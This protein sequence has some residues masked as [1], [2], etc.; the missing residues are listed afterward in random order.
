YYTDPLDEDS[1]ND[2]MFDGFEVIFGFNPLD[3]AD[4]S[5]DADADGL[6]NL[7][8]FQNNTN[9]LYADTDLDGLS[10]YQ[11]LYTYSTDPAD[12]DSDFDL[13]LD[14][15]EINLYS[16]D[17]LDADSDDDSYF[18]GYEVEFGFLPNN[19]NYP[20]FSIDVAVNDYQERPNYLYDLQMDLARIG[21]AVNAQI[22]PSSTY[23]TAVTDPEQLDLVYFGWSG[24]YHEPDVSQIFCEDPDWD[25]YH[26]DTSMDW[27]ETLGTGINEWYLQ[28]GLLIFP[29]D[30]EERIQHYWDWQQYFMDN[31]LAM[32]PGYVNPDYIAYW[33]YL[34]GYNHT[35]G[36]LQSL[37]KMWWAVGHTGQE[38]INSIV[39]AGETWDYLNPVFSY[40]NPTATLIQESILDPLIWYDSNE[41]PMPHLAESLEYINDTHVRIHIRQGIKWQ[42]DPDGLFTNEYLDADDVYFTLYCMKNIY[43]YQNEYPW[44]WLEKIEKVDQYTVD[45]FIDGNPATPENE[46][47]SAFLTYLDMLVIPEHYLNQTQLYDGKTPD[48]SHISWEIFNQ[49]P[50]GTGLMEFNYYNLYDEVSLTK[51][52]DCWWLNDT[53]TSDPNLNWIERFGDNWGINELKIRILSYVNSLTEFEAGRIDMVYLHGDVEQ[54]QIYETYVEEGT[55]ATFAIQSKVLPQFQHYAFNLAE[56]RGTPIQSRDPCPLYPDM[57]IGLAVRKAIAYALNRE[58]TNDRYHDG[59]WY[60]G[61]HPIFP[62]LGIWLNPGIITY[63][64]N[65]A[66]SIWL[67]RNA[68]YFVDVDSDGDGIM[69]Y[70]EMI[71]YGTD[72][73]KV[74]SDD[75]GISDYDEIF[76]TLTDPTN[77]DHDG[78]TMYDGFELA[79]GL[80]PF[81]PADGT[82][83]DDN[84]GLTN[85]EEFYYNTNIT[86]TDSD[87]DGITDGD[88]V[89]LY[90]SDPA[91]VDTDGDTLSDY[92][93]I[94]IHNSN[95][96]N[97]DTDGDGTDDKTEVELGFLPNDP[98]YPLFSLVGKTNEGPRADYMYALRDELAKIGIALDVQILVWSDFIMELMVYQDY[99]IFFVGLSGGSPDNDLPLDIYFDYSQ[100]NVAFGYDQGLDWNETYNEGLNQYLWNNFT[101]SYPPYSQASVDLYYLWQNYLMDSVLPL[102]PCYTPYENYAYWEE[103]DGYNAT[104]GII[105]SWGD[106]EW[107]STH[108]GQLVSDQLIINQEITSGLNQIWLNGYNMP[109]IINKACMDPLVWEDSDE[110]M[111]PHLAKSITHIDGN[112]IRIELREGIKWQTDP[113]GIFTNEYFDAEDV[114]FTLYCWK[115]FVDQSTIYQRWIQNIEIIDQYTIDVYIDGDSYFHYL[116][117]LSKILMMPEH[118]LNQTQLGDGITPDQGHNSW[119]IFNDHCF[120]TGLM[121]LDSSA[122]HYEYQLSVFEETWWKNTTITSDPLLDWENRFGSKWVMN[123]L[124]VKS[125]NDPEYA[126]DQFKAG[127][128]DILFLDTNITVMKEY[129]ADIRF[130][131]SKILDNRFD[132]FGFNL[133]EERG[134][135]L[136]DR[137]P[138]PGDPSIS[139]GLAVRKAI[140]Y[141]YDKVAMNNI[142]NEGLFEISYWP[143]YTS[144]EFWTY[145]DII[146][147]EFN[148]TKAVEYLQ[149]AGITIDSDG[150]G[151]E[152][153]VEII[154]YGTN[155]YNDDSDEDGLTDYAELFVYFTNP[156]V[157]DS[158][159]DGLLDGAEVNIYNTSPLETDTDT[160]GLDDGAEIIIYG[161]DPLDTD[162]DGDELSDGDEVNIY[163]TNPADTDS[164]NDEMP[165]GWEVTY[166]LDPTVD[167]AGYDEDSDGLVNLDEYSEGT[168]P[169]D[170]DSDAD[171]LLD[172]EEVHTYLSDPLN[173]DSDGDGIEDGIEVNTYGTNPILVDT[174]SD[175]ISDYD[176]IFTYFTDP[177]DIDSDSDS[178]PDGWEITYGLDPSN[179]DSLGDADSDGLLNG[180]E[181]AYGCDPTIAD[182][183]SDGLSDGDE[184]STYLTNPL[185]NDTD[186]DG[187]M[188][189]EEIITYLT[190]PTDYDTDDDS[191]SDGEEIAQGTDPNDPLDFPGSGSLDS[192]SDGLL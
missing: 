121:K 170:V 27:N 77:P 150:D 174:D 165:D 182:T 153:A 175:G 4:A 135:P 10:D 132:F 139:I 82:H 52:Q 138:C 39:I 56:E 154:A 51:Y 127:A 65:P 17:P 147:Y 12:P 78:D 152:N 47:Y 85:A 167:D 160:D 3:P 16:T 173:V 102:L 89:N 31:I 183:D 37:G 136:Q 128:L 187:L 142:V 6:T 41:K 43:P 169:T 112:H 61:E 14:G 106:M 75:D 163:G 124:I 113:E 91:S 24:E 93:E 69:N 50:F 131:I 137:S 109:N 104:K 40:Y 98:N 166:G 19:P 179:D 9:P 63:D 28:Q 181:Y 120:G 107:T 18:D 67:L 105:Q 88:E 76:T 144:N 97:T 130:D 155:P 58:E 123:S 13:L 53:I 149:L 159:M 30:S 73:F 38:D 34:V 8:E 115:N 151:I 29:P 57:T 114:Y 141:A 45:I 185:N 1:D 99:D 116:F 122:P 190:D 86:N 35:D 101:Q 54:K 22:M 74:D 176:E 129:E 180:E 36:L 90:G 42:N 186:S 110:Q 94:F 64:Y 92:D 143:I 188:D 33:D 79:N 161:T 118:Y 192:D 25:A 66:I 117:E 177:L 68:G 46:P 184:I 172:G 59:E 83:D 11:E 23:W 5:E 126:A 20:Y 15:D 72:T 103:L 171:G 164:D 70:D 178:M 133:R 125:Y 87:E 162:S 95:P 189:G 148:L 7:E 71:I 81:N 119:N 158:D 111:Y 96:A 145:D 156:L 80:D 21:I 49:Q 32:I 55:F 157:A 48:I 108:T 62:T 191:V 26:Y 84:D 146:R 134:T 44:E 100:I 140:A 168:D 2:L 60:I